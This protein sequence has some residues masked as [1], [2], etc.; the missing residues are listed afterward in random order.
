MVVERAGYRCCP[1]NCHQQTW[2][3]DKSRMMQ[4]GWGVGRSIWLRGK[5]QDSETNLRA[6]ETD[7]NVINAKVC[8]Q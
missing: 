1:G 5:P 7:E 8:N 4:L 2:A 3:W 6:Y